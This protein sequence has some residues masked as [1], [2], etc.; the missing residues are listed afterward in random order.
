MWYYARNLQNFR[1][2]LHFIRVTRKD[3]ARNK[4]KKKRTT[5]TRLRD[6]E[7][8]DT[9][10]SFNIIFKSHEIKN[11]TIWSED[12]IEITNAYLATG[13]DSASL[14]HKKK[15]KYLENFSHLNKIRYT[16]YVGSWYHLSDLV[17]NVIEDDN[18]AD[19]ATM[20]GWRPTHHR[21][22]K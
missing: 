16:L 12:N 11:L 1:K 19:A 13:D 5:L 4:K 7:N 8:D 15:K 9:H 22:K 21:K 17:R 2:K 6:H 14:L 10:Q 18:P 20:Q 3:L